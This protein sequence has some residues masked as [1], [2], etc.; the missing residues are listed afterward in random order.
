MDV[1]LT[2][3]LIPAS[4]GV[5]VYGELSIKDENKPFILIPTGSPT[6]W[7]NHGWGEHKNKASSASNM[8]PALQLL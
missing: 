5:R 6:V 2:S 4:L 8:T 1:T 7:P 3:Y